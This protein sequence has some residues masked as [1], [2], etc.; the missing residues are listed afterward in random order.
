[1]SDDG[2]TLAGVAYASQTTPPQLLLW[3][4]E[5][6]KLRASQPLPRSR[7]RTLVAFSPDG[8]T[9][10]TTW[11]APSSVA[12]RLPIAAQRLLRTPKAESAVM[13]WSALD[14]HPVAHLDARDASM[15]TDLA[16]SPDGRRVAAS[17]ISSWVMLWDVPRALAPSGSR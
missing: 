3:N 14:A 16:F 8:H 7:E 15:L 2:Q 13:L 10:A 9:L 11:T 6:G 12:E 17:S 1:M 5:T 4:A